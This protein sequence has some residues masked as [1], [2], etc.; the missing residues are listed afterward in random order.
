MMKRMGIW[1]LGIILGLLLIYSGY[2]LFVTTKVLNNYKETFQKLEHPQDTVLI[3]SFKFKFSYY[4]ATY[5]DESIQS[6]CAYLVG[7]IRSYTTDW[8]ELKTFYQGKALAQGDTN[9]IRVEVFPIQFVSEEGTV[10]SLDMDS[11]FLYSPFDVDVMAKLE[12]HYYFGGFPK[13]LI[14]NGIE[15]Y[16]VYIALDCE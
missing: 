12:S 3:D 14:E 11:S 16:A 5:R 1:G 2:D 13:A 7:E 4:P 15:V 6:Q 8:D 10:P 9:E